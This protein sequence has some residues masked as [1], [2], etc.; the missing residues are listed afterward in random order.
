NPAAA[1]AVDALQALVAREG[2]RLGVVGI[3]PMSDP[4]TPAWLRERGVT[5]PVAVDRAGATAQAWRRSSAVSAALVVGG[6]VAW[7]GNPTRV[8]AA[9]LDKHLRTPAP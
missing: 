5:F 8:D 1:P 9:L 6:K 4:A 7:T 3:T 2:A